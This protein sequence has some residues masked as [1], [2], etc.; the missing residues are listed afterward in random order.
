MDAGTSLSI[1]DLHLHMERAIIHILQFMRCAKR[2]PVLIDDDELE[3][4]EILE[5]GGAE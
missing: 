1:H 2:V 5:R 4:E 3:E